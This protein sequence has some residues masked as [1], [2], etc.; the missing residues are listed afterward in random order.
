MRTAFL[1][2]LATFVGVSAVVPAGAAPSL[3]HDP[4]SVSTTRADTFEV[5]VRVNAETPPLGCYALTLSYDP[6]VL[7]LL[8]ASEG[9]LFS[10]SA[11]PTFFSLEPDSSGNPEI[12]DCVLGF[13]TTV[14]PPGELVVLRFEAL[15]EGS[16]SIGYQVATL[17]DVDRAVITGVEVDSTAVLVGATGAP[18][19]RA[20][21]AALVAH[22]NPSSSLTRIELVDR[23]PDGSVIARRAAPGGSRLE[24]YDISGRRIT[25]LRW[26]SPAV[27][28]WNGRDALGRDVAAGIYFVR[29]R[30]D[31]EWLQTKLVRLD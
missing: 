8:D 2:L 16:T 18:V 11:D 15:A 6:A 26:S 31:G 14:T 27:A 19:A 28:N 20:R 29:L 17:R 1:L 24:V 7:R 3:V 12:T 10:Q 13:Q 23:R 4:A 22:P 5:A 21:G 30:L 25:E 9:S